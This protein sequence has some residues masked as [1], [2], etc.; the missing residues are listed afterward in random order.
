MPTF[1]VAKISPDAKLPKRAHEDDIGLDL[2]ASAKVE[3]NG[4]DTKPVSTGLII[5]VPRNHGGFITPRSGLALKQITV[6]NSPGLID[7]GYRGE[8]AVLLF[9]S[10]F[11]SYTIE[12][13]DKI[14]Q[15]V[16]WA[17]G[18]MDPI[19]TNKEDLTNTKRGKDGF[20]STGN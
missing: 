18:F 13:G 15:L 1:R 12:A 3:I 8:V 19:E 11:N 17:A 5:E 4:L 16:I 6:A 10:S 14:A 9:N 7:P 20:G 2:Y